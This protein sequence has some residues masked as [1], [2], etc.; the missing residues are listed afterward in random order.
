MNTHIPTPLLLVGLL[1]IT[2]LSG[3]LSGDDG[4]GLVV[5]D[6]P[7]Y[8]GPAPTYPVDIPANV[9]GF[10][11]IDQLAHADGNAVGRGSGIW[12]FGDRVYGS[13]LNLGFWIADISDP[14]HPVLLWNATVGQDDEADNTVTSFARD[15]DVIDHQDG[16]RTLV[17]A[18]QTDGIHVW[19]VTNDEPV[20]LSRVDVP[21]AHNLA[22]VPGTEYVF[23]SQ[24]GGLGRSN[25]LI[26]MSNPAE[27]VI[28]GAY[29]THG[30]HDITFY[31]TINHDKFRAYCAGI[32]RTELWNLDHFD[33]TASNFGIHV[34]AT[35]ED[36][37]DSPVV[38]NPVF[39]SAPLR[40][41][42][43]LAMVNED[44][45]VLMIGDEQNGGGEP[46]GCLANT[47]GVSSPTG[48]LWFYDL[49]DETN[50][51]LKSWISP[52]LVA[53]T[54]GAVNPNP[55]DPAGIPAEVYDILPNCTAHFGTL[56]PGQEKIAMAWYSAGVLLIDFSDIEAPVIL[57]QYTP[58]GTNPW[59][60]KV[61]GQYVFTGDM[62]RG[63]DVLKLV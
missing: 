63:M 52:P 58:E 50:P 44:A 38:G 51:V 23:N 47:N 28:V 20:F 2:A 46:G 57:A 14:E 62:G 21:N 32:Q 61:H 54:P 26:D 18:T 35:V 25:E 37:Q 11:F 60:A 36:I 10:H 53:P 24:S 1:A 4:D 41:L 39:S 48:A 6:D 9:Q 22:V 45:T 59:D 12:A 34:I 29:G 8:R 30:C 7:P 3:C 43:H 42:H 31:G 56:V 19:D 33:T 27:P 16:R 15:A 17:L 40:T 49:A 55:A 5:I 13:A